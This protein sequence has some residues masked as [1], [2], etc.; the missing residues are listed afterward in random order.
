MSDYPRVLIEETGEYLASKI[1]NNTTRIIELESKLEDP[2][3]TGETKIG[4]IGEVKLWLAAD[5]Q[6][7]PDGFIKCRGQ[8]LSAEV[9]SELYDILKELP[10]AT[11]ESWG[12]ANWTTEFDLPDIS[13]KYPKFYKPSDGGEGSN[14]Y[15]NVVTGTTATEDTMDSVSMIGII[16]YKKTG[17]R[18]DLEQLGIDMGFVTASD[19]ASWFSDDGFIVPDENAG[20]SYVTPEEV[21]SWFS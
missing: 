21:E 4:E 3:Y 5:D 2:Q 18:V 1:K 20:L 12:D 7:V 11:R 19:I 6:P 13:G 14:T 9:Y 15:T 16:R 10:S 8:R 17:L